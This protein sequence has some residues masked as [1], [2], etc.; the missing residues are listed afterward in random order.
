[1]KYFLWYLSSFYLFKNGYCQLQVKVC[2]LM[3]G[4]SLSLRLYRKS[5][6]MLTDFLDITITVDRDAKPQTKQTKENRNH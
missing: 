5:M 6:V 1:M 3:T 2:A 4:Y